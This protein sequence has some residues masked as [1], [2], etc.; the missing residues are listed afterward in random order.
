MARE[1][2]CGVVDRK[3]LCFPKEVDYRIIPLSVSGPPP[4]TRTVSPPP[5]S[6]SVLPRTPMGM[7]ENRIERA[8]KD[9]YLFRSSTPKRAAD[10]G[11][12]AE[13]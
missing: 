4:S 3:V 2:E 8:P 11:R 12:S 5:T 10:Y 6:S 7:I 9:D 13:R 1:Q